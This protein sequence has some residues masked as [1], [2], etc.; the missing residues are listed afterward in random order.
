MLIEEWQAKKLYINKAQLEKALGVSL[1]ELP[2]KQFNH[3]EPLDDYLLPYTSMPYFDEYTSIALLQGL[4]PDE[5]RYMGNK[6][7]FHSIHTALLGAIKKGELG[8]STY[9][10]VDFDFA[11][12]NIEHKALENWAKHYGYKWELPAYRP[13]TSEYENSTNDDSNSDEVAQLKN[14]IE[15]QA[16]QIADLQSQL[17]NL[18]KPNTQ[19]VEYTTI[20]DNTEKGNRISS[21]QRAIFSLLVMKCYPNHSTRN[22]LFNAI[23]VELKSNGITTKDLKY[24]TLDRLIDEDLRINNLSPFPPKIK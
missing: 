14:I 20:E 23:N 12:L 21:P 17:E 3:Q 2:T 15:Q 11:S 22:E 4:N 24:P 18:S 13:L 16:Q 1:S 9:Q 8:F 19:A 10:N 7:N 6:P 5:Y